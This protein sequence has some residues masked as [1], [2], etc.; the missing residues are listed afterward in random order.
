MIDFTLSNLINSNLYAVYVLVQYKSQSLIEHIRTSWRKFGDLP[1][2]FITVVPPQM[3]KESFKEWYRGTADSVYQNI[4]L[5]Y[6]FKPKIVVILGGDH[7]Y[8]MNINEMIDFHIRKKADLTLS[9][10][11]TQSSEA[12]K[13]GIPQINKDMKVTGFKEKPT[14]LKQKS[15]FASMGNYVFN[16]DFLIESLNKSKAKNKATDFG[17]DIIPYLIKKKKRVFAYDFSQNRIPFLNRYEAK[18]YWKDVGSIPDYFQANM[19]LLGNKPILNLDN[20]HWP[21]HASNVY[22]P[23][24]YISGG[25]IENTLVSEGSNAIGSTIKN[26]IIGRSV[27]IERGCTIEDSII[28]DFTRIEK[29]CHI[30]RTIIDRFNIIP[31]NTSIG[32]NLK[33]DSQKYHV[34]QSGIV[35]IKRGVRDL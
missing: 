30:K 11:P 19:D 35:V 27:F 21:I 2:Q 9:V 15:I 26:S 20:R 13:F 12:C 31:K 5:I 10:I 8:R 7:I 23:P 32:F 4:N 34:D 6:D 18:Y 29:S 22:L 25:N 33:H 1:E 28:M 17:K 24:A 3:R 16:A 14:S